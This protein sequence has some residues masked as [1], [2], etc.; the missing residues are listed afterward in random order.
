MAV[1]VWNLFFISTSKRFSRLFRI[2]SRERDLYPAETLSFEP[3]LKNPFTPNDSQT[4][5][6]AGENYSTAA[7]GIE[8]EEGVGVGSM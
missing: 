3:N 2:E 8:M 7:R 1:K 5:A 4:L 6:P